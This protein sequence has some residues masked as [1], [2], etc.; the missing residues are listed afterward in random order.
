MIAGSP[1]EELHFWRRTSYPLKCFRRHRK[2]NK[3]KDQYRKNPGSGFGVAAFYRRH[4]PHPYRH[5]SW[6]MAGFFR[7]DVYHH[8]YL[9]RGYGGTAFRAWTM[10]LFHNPVSRVAV[11]NLLILFSEQCGRGSFGENIFTLQNLISLVLV[12]AGIFLVNSAKH[13]IATSIKDQDNTT[14]N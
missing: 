5:I 2:R 10:L 6:R 7:T 13:S 14:Q 1:P 9:S 3:Q 11:Y 12:C 8:S 4:C